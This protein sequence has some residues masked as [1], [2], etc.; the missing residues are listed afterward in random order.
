MT[1]KTSEAVAEE[2]LDLQYI[3]PVKKK[4]FHGLRDRAIKAKQELDEVRARIKE[5]NK[6]QEKGWE[7]EDEDSDIPEDDDDPAITPPR[8]QRDGRQ[9][10]GAVRDKLLLFLSE[11]P[12]AKANA[13]VINEGMGWISGKSQIG[14]FKKDGWI[15]QEG[16]MRSDYFLTDKGKERLAQLQANSS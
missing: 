2:I 10:K 11:Q 12:E 16:G 7:G 5:L 1:E 13:S 8:L 15:G 6:I 4:L 14:S 9:P 3:E